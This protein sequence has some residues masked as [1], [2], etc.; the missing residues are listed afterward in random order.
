MRPGWGLPGDAAV[1]AVR[2]PKVDYDGVERPLC[3]APNGVVQQGWGDGRHC[4]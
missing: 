1:F 2:P 3:L 4:K